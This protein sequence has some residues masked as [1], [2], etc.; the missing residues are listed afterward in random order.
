MF[1]FLNGILFNDTEAMKLEKSDDD[2][3]MVTKNLKIMYIGSK[4]KCK[5]YM[6]QF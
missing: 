4:K 5:T 2:Q 3:W 6:S 1:S